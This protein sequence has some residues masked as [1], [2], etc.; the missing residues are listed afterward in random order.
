M[1]KQWTPLAKEIFGKTKYVPDD[2]DVSLLAG[3]LAELE[4]AG[5]HS[6]NQRLIQANRKIFDTLSELNFAVM[7]VRHLGVG[8]EYEPSDYGRRPID[9]RVRGQDTVLHLQMKRFG[10]LE[11]D[12]R[13][14]AIYERIKEGAKRINVGKFFGIALTEDFAEENVASFLQF[15]AA[16]APHAVNASVHDFADG[17]RILASVDFWSPSSTELHHLTLG[18][19]SD[20][21]VV[22]ITG[23]AAD[24]L[25]SSIR[26]AATAFTASVDSKNLNLVVAESDKHHDIDICEACFGTEEELF[27]P[28][29]KHAWH[30][31]G[32]GVFAAPGIAERVAGLVVLRRSDRSKPVSDY[33]AFL[34]INEPHF[35]WVDEIRKVVPLAK[36]LRYNMRP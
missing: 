11:R 17:G 34:L 21:Q 30:R 23:L 25:R 31:L 16:T 36:V 19:G 13:R 12:A 3:A 35:K 4:A 15:L 26:K 10:D 9:F 1:V 33:E 5:L 2:T 18:V 14:D 7:L 27:G 8:I 6:L 32:D 20:A 24:Q 29:G 22:N 28:G